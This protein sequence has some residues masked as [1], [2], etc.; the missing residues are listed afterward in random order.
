MPKRTLTLIP[1][2]AP[3]AQDVLLS[4]NGTAYTGTADGS[5]WAVKPGAGQARRVANTGGRPLGLEWLPD[6]RLLVCDALKGLL[7]VTSTGQVETLADAVDGV[8]M[9][10]C[11]NAAVLRDGSIYFTDASTKWSL[12]QW[13]SDLVED[14]CTGRLLRLVPGGTPQVLLGG[15]SFATGVAKAADES[16]VTVAETGHRRIRRYYLSGPDAGNA[17]V[18]VEDLPAHPNNSSLGTDGLIWTTATSPAAPTLALLQ[19][20]PAVLRAAARRAPVALK[21]VPKRTAR[22]AAYDDKGRLVHD[23][24][25][26]PTQWHLATGVREHNGRVWLAS[27]REPALA[28]VDLRLRR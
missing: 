17:D 6:G 1:I 26:D 11:N 18:F 13:Q 10:L 21:R 27:M 3:G 23:V 20:A 7:A 5:I 15:L 4:A 16:F 12:D 19:K 28:F 24:D 22:V 2:P 9:R 25:C 14:T 8:R